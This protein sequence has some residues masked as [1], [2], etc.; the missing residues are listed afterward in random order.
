MKK[1][2]LKTQVER[3]KIL[4]SF[5]DRIITLQEECIHKWDQALE[6]IEDWETNNPYLSALDALN[7]SEKL[8]KLA[9][10]AR[11]I[12]PETQAKIQEIIDEITDLTEEY[13]EEDYPEIYSDDYPEMG[14]D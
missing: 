12:S 2:V 13:L 11:R 3:L 6:T 5:Y 14:R 7:A 4:V 10:D 8:A 9:K 1:R